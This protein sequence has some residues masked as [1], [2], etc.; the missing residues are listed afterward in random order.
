MAA[1]VLDIL[2]DNDPCLKIVAAEVDDIGN[3]EIQQLILDM[4]ATMRAAPG[5]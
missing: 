3:S 2:H 1:K 5:L 4:I